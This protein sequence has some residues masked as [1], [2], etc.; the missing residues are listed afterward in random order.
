M[1]HCFIIDDAEVVRKYARLI[2]ESLG[3]RVSEAASPADVLERIQAE[4]PDYILID[5][6]IPGANPIDFIA[7]VRAMRLETRPYIIYVP[8]ENDFPEIERAFKA[9]ADNYILKPFNREIVE[10]KLHEIRVAA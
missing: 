4:P 7:R 3:F 6:R 1:L 10:L 2:F 8:T 5:W 9:G